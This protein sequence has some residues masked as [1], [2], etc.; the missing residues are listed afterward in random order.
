MPRSPLALTRARASV[1]AAL[2]VSALVATGQ[3]ATAAPRPGLLS[4]RTVG[5]HDALPAGPC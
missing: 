2:T 1:L 3:P 5:P 4:S